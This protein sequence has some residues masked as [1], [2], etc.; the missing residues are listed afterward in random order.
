MSREK[1]WR[2]RVVAELLAGRAALAEDEP[3]EEARVR[4]RR[5][6]RM[7]WGLERLDALKRAQK[8][9]DAAWMEMLAPYDDLD[10]EDLPDFDAPPEELAVEA[11]H[12]ELRAALDEDRW[13]AHLHWTL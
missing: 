6:A 7:A 5:L 4:E 8:A 2:C 3:A 13:P 9:M 1:A 10:E 11:I 12:K